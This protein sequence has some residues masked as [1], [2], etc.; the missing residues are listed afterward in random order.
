[1]TD[2]DDRSQGGPEGPSTLMAELHLEGIPVLDLGQLRDDVTSTLPDSEL[3]DGPHSSVIAMFAHQA[4]VT[5]F[6]DGRRVP[7]STA[8]MR[9]NAGAEPDHS[10]VDLSQTWDFPAAQERLNRCAQEVLVAEVMGRQ[11]PPEQ[12]VAAFRAVLLA[13]AKQVNP[14]AVWWPTS[15]LVSDAP[16]EDSPLLA[17]LINV[18]MFR[19]GG[20]GGDLLMDTVGLAAIGLPD[21]Q[22][23]FRG[24]EPGLVAALLYNVGNYLFETGDVIEDGHT[25]EGLDSG[26]RW[27][28]QHENSVVAPRRI[29]LDINPGPPYAVGRGSGDSS[30]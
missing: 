4:F 21:V 18:R 5:D 7:I 28:C 12:R 1:M 8:V 15:T 2:E 22:C 13:V 3:L 27:R 14:L 16:A 26:Q 11:R 19:I 9:T 30:G 6:A 20:C 10:K 23:H 17:G 29:V 25:V 24:L